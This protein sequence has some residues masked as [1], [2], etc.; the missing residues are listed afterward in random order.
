MDTSRLANCPAPAARQV[1]AL[2]RNPGGE[3]DGKVGG[4][5]GGLTQ[6]KSR[7]CPLLRHFPY[8]SGRVAGLQQFHLD[9][10]PPRAL[11]VP[12]PDKITTG[13]PGGGQTISGERI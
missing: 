9:G 13:T 2:H 1:S 10:K 8:R 12:A 7:L 11:R 5:A 4:K 3:A 6:I